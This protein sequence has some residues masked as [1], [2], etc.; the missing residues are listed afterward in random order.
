MTLHAGRIAGV[1]RLAFGGAANAAR[2]ETLAGDASVR[3][4]HRVWLSDAPGAAPATAMLMHD[5]RPAGDDGCGDDFVVLA[6][7]LRHHGVGVPEI[8]ARDRDAGLYLLED[9]GDRVLQ[10]E[11][12]A[13]STER[14]RALYRAALDVLVRLCRDASAAAPAPTPAHSRFFDEAKLGWELDFF[15]THTIEGLWRVALGDADREALRTGFATLVASLAQLPRVFVH[16]DYH[17]RNLLVQDVETIRVVDFQDARL[18]PVVYDLASLLRD[19]YLDLDETEIATHLEEQRQH[20]VDAGVPVPASD[21]FIADF[22]RMSIQR[23][24]KALGTFG[25]QATQRGKTGYLEAVPRTVAR[26]RACLSRSPE[27][28]ALSARLDPILV[29]HG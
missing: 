14:R 23:G 13:A 17:S 7:H 20:L 2:V 22:D 15:V 8:Y 3:S 12:K 18:G 19:S 25:F 5:P 4:F 21:E 26:V 10:E 16:R 9:L 24:L 6:R 1:I 28:A 29:D 11:V 27:L